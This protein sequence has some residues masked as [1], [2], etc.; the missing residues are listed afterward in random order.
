M[1]LLI[2]AT[3]FFVPCIA[4]AAYSD[5]GNDLWNACTDGAPGHN[6]LCI[7]LPSAYFDMM[8]AMGYRCSVTGVD[9]GQVRD[10]LLKYLSDNPGKRNLPASELAITSL[11]STFRCVGPG[12]HAAERKPN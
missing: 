4:N 11:K 8:L 5:T 6:Y 7:G 1:K 12:A 3:L 9:R 2:A 10:V